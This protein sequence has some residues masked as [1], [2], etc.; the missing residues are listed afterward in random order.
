[1]FL[2]SLPFLAQEE[3]CIKIHILHFEQG[4]VP[5]QNKFEL[6]HHFIAGPILVK[7]LQLW[8]DIR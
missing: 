6:F 4:N 2:L 3:N 7:I 5:Q 8:G 1:M